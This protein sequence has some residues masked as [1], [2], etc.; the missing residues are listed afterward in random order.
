MKKKYSQLFLLF[1]ITFSSI[2][3]QNNEAIIQS[4]LDSNLQKYGLE[5]N[6]VEEWNIKS[7]VYS[8][9][10]ETTHL[11]LQQTYRGIPIFGAVANL[12]IKNEEVFY[13]NV[14]FISKAN[15]NINT[16][17]TVIN[18][19]GAIEKTSSLMNL[20]FVSGVSE[21]ENP[22]PNKFIFSKS[23]VSL[24]NIPVQLVFQ[25]LENGELRLSWD[26]SIYPLNK[27][28]WWSV[29]ID[30]NSGEVLSK[31]NWN[32]SCDFTPE[33][34]EGIVNITNEQN[35]NSSRVGEGYNV[36]TIPVESPNHG[37]R[38]T[39][40]DPQNLIASPYGWHDTDAADGAEYTITRGNNVYAQQDSD[41]NNGTNGYAPDGGATL[42]FDFPIDFN[43]H[44]STYRDA[45]LTN[46]FYVN[47]IM[48][49]VWYQYGFDVQSGNFQD[50]VYGARLGVGGDYVIADGQDAGARNNANFATP[51]DGSI[52]RMQMY[53]WDQPNLLFVNTGTLQGAYNANDSNFNDGA[54]T[55]AASGVHLSD[56]NSA[57]IA[58]LVV[59]DDGTSDGTSLPSEGCNA[60]INGAEVNG[61][62]AVIRR[63]NCDFT[64][65]I[66]NAQN[67]GAIGVIMV[68]NV[69]SPEVIMGGITTTI[70]I[71][72]IS[73]SQSLGESL[74]SAIE[75]GETIN[76]SLA[77]YGLDGSFD[78][79][80]VAHEY[81][82]G[83]SNRLIGGATD[84]GCMQNSEQL[85]E[86]WSD[87]FA[88][89]ITMENGDTESDIRGIGTYAMAQDTEATGIRAFPYS[90]DM[91][92][93]PFTFADSNTQVVP[94]GL[95]SVWATMIWDLNWRM[96]GA[97]GFD[98]DI[99]NGTGGN[100]MTMSLIIEGLKLTPC[101]SGFVEAR[102]AIIA[103]DDALYGGANK[104]LIWQVFARRGLGYS[105]D[106]GSA[107]SSTDQS[108]SF[109]MPPESE[110]GG[111]S[112]SLS[113]ADEVDG[114]KLISIY[115]NPSDGNITIA[116]SHNVREGALNI[117][118]INGREVH[119]S[120]LDF[121]TGT[122]QN[123][124]LKLATGLY[125]VKFTTNNNQSVQKIIIE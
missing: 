28:H 110:L 116:S 89:M 98:A 75:G 90:T 122:N 65:K 113:V 18:P 48:H 50:H 111:A 40:T 106:S 120:K 71:P 88:L 5:Q 35:Q 46:L 107:T 100:N 19:S 85:G 86:G 123:V 23:G 103:A 51:P 81:G 26:L 109:D 15:E 125:I 42:N 74:I 44:T 10:S 67:A 114:F 33:N 112:C 21:L 76:A 95:G 8:E 13:G 115:P 3:S 43:L 94:H 4:Y 104:C 82:H 57:I 92:I 47:N 63:G 105:A 69:A 6:D 45:S 80:I 12:S 96:I 25:P 61:K 31:Y 41:N 14:S 2:Y 93:N 29:R 37:A 38:T 64:V 72:A 68:N 83:I 77:N 54:P 27:E 62:I 58:D 70:N 1:F 49:D 7:E 16:L 99:Y 124:S 91:A 22:E 84:V 66:Q 121:S 73:I 118:D 102:D 59:V 56:L 119:S 24:E 53:V 32:V 9:K 11:Y 30:A 87:F 36:Y 117:F 79:G 52:P 55:P 17:S 20:G 78:N 108:E 39:I 34:F 97:Y 60:L 101:S